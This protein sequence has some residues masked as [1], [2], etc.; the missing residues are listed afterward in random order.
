LS[1]NFSVIFVMWLRMYMII[2]RNLGGS[3]RVRLH[4]CEFREQAMSGSTTTRLTAAGASLLLVLAVGACSRK[5]AAGTVPPAP[6][7]APAAS[8]S[9]TAV[10]PADPD[11][12][13]VLQ[14]LAGLGGKPIET[15]SATEARAQPT[16]ADAVQVVMRQRSLPEPALG[17]GAVEDRS[18]NGLVGEIPIR[19][20]TPDGAG[21]FPVIVYFHGGGWV[22]G[23]LD[24]HDASARALAHH[25]GAVVVSS[26]YRQGPEHRFPA[27]HDDT[28]RAYEW[29]VANARV[30][31]GI[32]EQVAVAGEGAGGNLAAA[33]ALRARDSGIQQPA[34][35]VLVYPVAGTDLTTPS[36][37]E[38]ADARPLNK[39]MMEWFFRQY[40]APGDLQNPWIDLIAA[41]LSGLPPTT[42]IAA[43]IDPLRSEGQALAEQMRTAGVPV[44]YRLYPGVTHAFFGTGAV[45]QAARDAAELAGTELKRS[46]GKAAPSQ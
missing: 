29:T 36:Y 37:G 8:A 42:I 23:D 28:F 46:F 7:S 44:T 39:A 17:I 40:L 18:I 15:L 25:A 31:G 9:A 34:H 2:L 13:L 33:V 1:K 3:A 43:G 19:I 4:G 22:I 5:Q 26:R 35:A 12:R 6:A 21:P 11:M 32:P 41:D 16:V 38:H 20:Y 30:I 24:T 14:A 10:V 27:A 45:V